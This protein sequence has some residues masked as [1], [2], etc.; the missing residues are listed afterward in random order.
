MRGR[1]FGSCSLAFPRRHPYLG[2]GTSFARSCLNPRLDE[3][4]DQRTSRPML[5]TLIAAALT[6][7]SAQPMLAQDAIRIDLNIPALRLAVYE[8][9]RLLETYPIAVGM[10]G[11][12]TPTGEFAISH[13]EWN[14]W[15]H[16]PT[17]RE[18]ARDEKPTP[19][20]PLNPM[21][22]VKL[23]FLPL[24]FVHGTPEGESIGTPASHGCV[25]MLN[26]DVVELA[27]LLHERAAPQVSSSELER[28]ATKSGSTQRVNFRE[29]ITVA[30]RY[31]PIVVER[32]EI[33]AYPDIYN[34]SAIHSE[35]VYQALIAAGYDVSSLDDQEVQRFVDRA[36]DQEAPFV[37]RLDEAFSNGLALA[38][39]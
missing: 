37:L 7:T 33:F 25:R 32:N 9:D 36:R 21:G 35:G 23:F 26:S 5:R 15:W 14:P 10:P 30:I 27:R 34:R 22:K 6:I 11:F 13:A 20:G 24:Y 29:K 17:H 18:W 16:P 1:G 38:R 39:S 2:I 12:D 31:D 19:P 4:V 28:M 8:G 3:L